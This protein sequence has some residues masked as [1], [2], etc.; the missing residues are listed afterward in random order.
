MQDKIGEERTGPSS[1]STTRGVFPASGEVTGSLLR[2]LLMMANGKVN[3]WGRLADPEVFKLPTH[4]VNSH[5]VHEA[6]INESSHFHSSR[7][8]RVC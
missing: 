4:L 5:K 8:C 6:I 2:E 7:E 3:I 1:S